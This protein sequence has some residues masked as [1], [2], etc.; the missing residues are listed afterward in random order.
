[1][2]ISIIVL[3]GCCATASFAGTY[4][5]VIHLFSRWEED[6]MYEDLD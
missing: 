5:A 3:M 1:M 2:D 4:A 6:D